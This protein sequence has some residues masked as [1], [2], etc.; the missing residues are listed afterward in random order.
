MA[1]L[2][3]AFSQRAKREQIRAD[4]ATD[5]DIFVCLVFQS[6][7]QVKEF[8]DK[9]EWIDLA[10]RS[11]GDRQRYYDGLEVAKMMGITIESPTPKPINIPDPP[12]RWVELADPLE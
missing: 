4:D 10:E 6:N 2:G 1:E 3:N 11:E 9:T 7:T 8:L 5:G 12:K